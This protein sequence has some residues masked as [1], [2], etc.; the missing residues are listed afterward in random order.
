MYLLFS[1]LSNPPLSQLFKTQ[2]KFWRYEQ[3]LEKTDPDI[4]RIYET[5]QSKKDLELKSIF[6]NLI[7]IKKLIAKYDLKFFRGSSES[8]TDNIQRYFKLDLSENKT[9]DFD[10]LENKFVT[11]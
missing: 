2:L 8:F 5:D 11:I 10:V 1:L 6:E 3:R 4:F 9:L 7:K